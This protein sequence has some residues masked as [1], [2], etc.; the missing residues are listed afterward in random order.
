MPRVLRKGVAVG[1]QV[2]GP[3]QPAQPAPPAAEIHTH[4]TA[5]GPITG[6][7]GSVPPPGAPH[8]V[9]QPLSQA[10]IHEQ[11]SKAR[12][13]ERELQPL[14]YGKLAR[15][16]V[17]LSP[18]QPAEHAH[19]VQA[20]GEVIAAGP[21]PD[22]PAARAASPVEVAAEILPGSGIPDPTL[23]PMGLLSDDPLTAPAPTSAVVITPIDQLDRKA[24]PAASDSDSPSRGLPTAIKDPGKQITGGFGVPLEASYFAL[25]GSE[26]R[27]VVNVLMED[28]A[29][30]LQN[31]LRFHMALTYPRV[32]ARVV[33]EV[34]V[35]QQPDQSFDVVKVYKPNDGEMPL[36]LA[37]QH[38]DEYCFVVVSEHQEVNDLGESVT[39][40][41]LVRADLGLPIP[42]KRQFE[43][44]SGMRTMADISVPGR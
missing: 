44:G 37:K 38:A 15:P 32:R 7:V 5:A 6:G 3:A 21:A 14:T 8:E 20:A 25:D 1:G 43:T 17:D 19:D 33:L 10:L 41:N 24:F 22:Q 18:G 30:R 40:P 34:N 27:E 4:E 11:L 12:R 42:A 13:N 23:S 29:A 16:A 35:F 39:A 9:T 2:A 31:D 28:L 36:D 26:L